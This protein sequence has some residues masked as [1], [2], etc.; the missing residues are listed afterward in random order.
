M[1]PLDVVAESWDK[2][3]EASNVFS[4]NYKGG[5][6]ATVFENLDLH[7]GRTLNYTHELSLEAPIRDAR[8]AMARDY[9]ARAMDAVEHCDELEK[10]I[11]YHKRWALF[12]K[13]LAFFVRPFYNPPSTRIYAGKARNV[14]G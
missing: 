12:Y 4:L 11:K 13:V 10:K 5:K 8:V 7:T 3:E 2:M 6:M 9:H 14:E 1:I